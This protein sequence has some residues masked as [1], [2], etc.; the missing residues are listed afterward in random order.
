MPRSPP[1]P[2]RMHGIF[3]NT[4]Y[5]RANGRM[6]TCTDDASVKPVS[7]GR[8]RR[9]AT[10]APDCLLLPTFAETMRDRAEGAGGHA[11]GEGA[12]RDHAGRARRRRGHLVD[13]RSTAGRR[14]PRSR[15]ARCRRCRPS[16]PPTRS[17]P[18]S[19]RSGS[20]CCRPSAITRST[21]A[22]RSAARGWTSTFPARAEGRRRQH[23][24]R[25]R[26]YDQWQRSPFADAYLGRMAAALAESMQLGTARNDRRARGQ[27]LEPRSRRPRVRPAQPGG[28]G[29]VRPPRSHHRHAARPARR[30]VGRDEYVV[31]LSADH[32]VTEFPSSSRPRARDGGRLDTRGARPT[33][34]SG[35]PQSA[36]GPGRHVARVNG[37]DVYFEP[38]VYDAAARATGAIDAVVATL[39]AQP[40]VDAGL[41]QRGAAAQPRLERPA[42]ARRRAQLR[43]GPQRR[44]G[45]RAEAGLD[46]LAAGTTHG[47]ANPDDQRVPVAVRPGIKPGRYDEAVDAGRHRADAGGAVRHHDAA[48]RGPAAARR[49]PASQ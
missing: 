27:L 37:N 25:R 44:S 12:Q 19:A 39:A 7:Y 24:T 5:D 21:R 31:A 13:D 40:G 35:A 47:S 42:A 34:S 36:L 49:P 17:T 18:T 2:F 26:F 46:V 30:L 4:W 48:R 11:V 20:A 43:P 45:D 23:Q 14:R 32:G 33:C 3:Q 22:R 10:T 29:H 8:K 16:S 9:R 28:A 6:A 41:P 15:R 38:G 1:A